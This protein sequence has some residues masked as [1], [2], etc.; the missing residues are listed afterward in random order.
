MIVWGTGQLGRVG[1][2]AILEDPELELVG[3]HA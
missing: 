2:R 3:V 1:L